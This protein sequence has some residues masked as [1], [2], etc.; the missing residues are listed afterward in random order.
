MNNHGH[1]DTTPFAATQTFHPPVQERFDRRMLGVAIRP[2][3]DHSRNQVGQ[4]EHWRVIFVDSSQV[5]RQEKHSEAG[6]SFLNCTL[7]CNIRVID[8]M[9]EKCEI[10]DGSGLRP[11]SGRL[12]IEIIVATRFDCVNC[13]NASSSARPCQASAL[14]CAIRPL[15]ALPGINLR[16]R[17][18]HSPVVQDLENVPLSTNNDF[19]VLVVYQISNA[20][21]IISH[22]VSQ[23][24]RP[25][26]ERN[27][28]S[29]SYDDCYRRVLALHRYTR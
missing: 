11:I 21:L 14:K 4:D 6:S 9:A 7:L 26:I 20:T 18:G 24:A 23:H 28:K 1:A 12:Q 15:P 3:I 10:M 5:C 8:D 27:R 17:Q 29:V 2:G 16:Q 25:P 19:V 22:R 13:A